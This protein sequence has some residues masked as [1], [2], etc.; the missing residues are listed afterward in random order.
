LPNALNSPGLSDRVF[1]K[2]A[3]ATEERS[4]CHDLF[5][6]PSSQPVRTVTNDDVEDD[7]YDAFLANLDV[8][9]LVSQR[10]ESTGGNDSYKNNNNSFNGSFDYGSQWGNDEPRQRG[11]SSSSFGGNQS[12]DSISPRG[13]AF[14]HGSS[15]FGGA[16]LNNSRN[17]ND[18]N[19]WG[20]A[21]SSFQS[22]SAVL[23]NAN[24]DPDAPLCPGH[25][26]PCQK[27]TSQRETSSGRQF[28]KCSLPDPDKCDFFAWADGLEI[29]TNSVYDTGGGY[30]SGEV[31]DIVKESRYKFGHRDFRP[32]QKE[33]VENA[34]AGRDVFVLMPTGGGKSLCYQLPAWCCPG[35]SVVVSPL[36]SLIQDQ[37]QSMTKLGVESVSLSSTQDFD[38]EQRDIMR[39]LN[40]MTA[41]GGIKLLYITPEKLGSSTMTQ[42]ILRQLY[43]KSLISRF[44]IDE[45]H[46]VSDWGHDFRCDYQR[47]GN[48][49]KEFAGVPLMALTATANEKVV[50][51][52]VRNLRMRNPYR[53]VS[54]FNRPNLRYEV[55][56]KE[57]NKTV[58]EIADFIA[59]RAQDSGVIYCLSKKDCEKLA[60]KLQEKVRSKPGCSRVRISFYHAEV[61]TDEKVKRH[62]EWSNGFIS[63]LCATIAFGMG[64]YICFGL[65][66]NVMSSTYHELTTLCFCC[67]TQGLT[68]RMSAMSFI[69]LCRNPL[70]IITKRAVVPVAIG[71][72]RTVS[73]TIATKTKRS[74]RT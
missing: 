43:N 17:N 16:G 68:S 71:K 63:V 56:K 39:R 72:P 12:F 55:R 70:L 73:S 74:W 21:N 14:D 28:Y 62:R 44:V 61:P 38:T 20:A 30:S 64:E 42:S 27:F 50:D 5:S 66:N 22:A 47:L 54:S 24:A 46:C 7:A 52:T 10:E 32:G 51:D 59:G 67:A 1:G 57:G 65:F 60:E 18:G 29:N 4:R 13:G 11:S 53:Y 2:Q 48:L 6:P 49:R 3:A 15:P 36:L 37:V 19:T 25:S 34:I 35:L 9:Q 23:H 58:D 8:D 26:L 69:T 33:I 41:H 45:A 40:Q 31:K